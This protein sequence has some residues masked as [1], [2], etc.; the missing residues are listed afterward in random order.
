[1][2]KYFFIFLIFFKIGNL[3]A[4]LDGRVTPIYLEDR[5]TF[6]NFEWVR[7][8]VYFKKGFDLPLQGT[9]LFDSSEIVNE[10]IRFQNSTIML[11]NNL[12]LG[13]TASM[14]G[15]GHIDLGGYAIKL[16]TDWVLNSVDTF[17]ITSSG[18]I[19]GES[20]TVIAPGNG[21]LI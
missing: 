18:S 1:M 5:Y 13:P 3:C 11:K 12:S 16:Q 10:G 6:T 9:V 20:D 7:G 4:V 8:S 14:Y 19:I 17:F 15:I 2:L 21:A